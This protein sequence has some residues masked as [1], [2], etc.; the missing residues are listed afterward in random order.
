MSFRQKKDMGGNMLDLI[1]AALI[2]YG[3]HLGL[4]S[5]MALLS[6]QVNFDFLAGPRDVTPELSVAVQR[7]KRATANLGES[8][9]IFLALAILAIV[10]GKQ[11]GEAAAIWLALR[12]V[13]T[14]IYIMGVAHIRTLVWLG[15]IV[16]LIM[17]A[18]ALV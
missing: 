2:V 14:P 6:G 12:L 18:L 8:L 11:A 15:S 13:Y 10:M 5:T 16:C 17:M 9:P 4:P 1:F 7:A 3:I